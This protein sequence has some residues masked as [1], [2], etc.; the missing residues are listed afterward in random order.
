[1]VHSFTFYM[2]FL[3]ALITISYMGKLLFDIGAAGLE[4]LPLD[5]SKRSLDNQMVSKIYR[6]SVPA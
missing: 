3:A 6:K 5:P 2:E 4:P 1:M